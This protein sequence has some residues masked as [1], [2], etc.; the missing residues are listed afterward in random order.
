MTSGTLSNI[1]V[2]ELK[3]YFRSA[4]NCPLCSGK[5]FRDIF[6]VNQLNFVECISCHFR[7]MNPYLSEK[8]MSLLYENSEILS[9]VN[10]A[11]GRYYEYSDLH[12]SR[13]VRDYRTV[14]NYAKQNF[15]RNEKPKL[16]EVGYGT[17]G[18]LLEAVKSGWQVDG[19][20]TSRQNSEYLQNKY[21]LQVR[22]G[23]FDDFE[24]VQTNYQMVALWDVIEHTMTPRS[25]LKKAYQM[26]PPGG[27]LVLATPNISGLLNQISEFVYTITGCTVKFLVRRLYV[28]EHVGYYTPKT[29]TSL[30]SQE[31]FELKT[32]LFTET[33]LKRYKFS[34]F[35]QVCLKVFFLIAKYIRRQNRMILVAQKKHEK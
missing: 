34:P 9:Q 32:L 30:I 4:L 3:K 19:I 17:G 35:L 25:Y 1:N 22:C 33:D 11:L 27:L 10:P 29:L 28:F 5:K 26:L 6:A 12:N 20:E 14:L 24:A 18:F 2:N 7:F 13:T 8:G 31:G 16:F 21:G 23:T 15:G